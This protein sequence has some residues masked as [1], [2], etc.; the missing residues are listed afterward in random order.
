VGGAALGP[1][2]VPQYRGMPGQE[3]RSGWVGGGA[4]SRRQREGG[5]NT[6]FLKWRR[7]KGKTIE[8]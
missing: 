2:G 4:P 6:D 7:G 3:G 5:W 1:E 8:M